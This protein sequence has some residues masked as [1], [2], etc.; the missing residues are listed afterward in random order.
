MEEILT[1][2]V[3]KLQ[4]GDDPR[5]VERGI[6]LLSRFASIKGEGEQ[7]LPQ[8]QA[9]IEEFGLA[10]AVLAPL[11]EVLEGFH[12]RCPSVP[13]TVDMGLVRGIAYYT[14]MVF[15]VLAP[16]PGDPLTLCGGGRYDGLVK[17][18]GGDGDVP[19]LGFA[20]NVDTLLELL[21]E[22]LEGRHLTSSY[23]QRR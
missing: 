23:P 5:R 4:R 1:R 9:A 7:V 11:E 10:H 15:E 20:Y 14:G 8:L 12:Q 21:P 2:F 17:A 18:L 16:G 6:S 19:A 13:I 3:Q 22:K